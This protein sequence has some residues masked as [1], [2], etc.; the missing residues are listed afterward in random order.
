MEYAAAEN[1]GDRRRH[2]LRTRATEII[3]KM[4]KHQKRID[5]HA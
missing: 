4:E 3:S 2:C 5:A 1:T